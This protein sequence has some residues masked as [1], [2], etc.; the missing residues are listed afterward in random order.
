MAQ[1][2]NQLAP[3]L[4]PFLE[5]LD[6]EM[7]AAFERVDCFPSIIDPNTAPSRFLDGLLAHLG[8]PFILEEGLTDLEKRRLALALFDIYELKGTCPGIIGA[9]RILY[10][11]IV[12]DCVQ[13]N[14]TG[15]ILDVDYLGITTI[16]AGSTAQERRTFSVMVSQNLTQ[17]QREQ[18][19]NVV[20]YMKPAN[21]FFAG[22]IEPGVPR[23][24]DH[25]VLDISKLGKNTDLH[26]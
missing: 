16:L 10:G 1:D 19:T 24:I 5:A 11:I 25:W 2:A 14:T 22:F 13:V 20:E 4:G 8:N 23:F 3:F 17:K 6:P 18:L 15:W 9:I 21:T 26:T 12:T 7:L